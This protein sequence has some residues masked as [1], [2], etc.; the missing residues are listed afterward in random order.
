MTTMERSEL[1]HAG[2]DLDGPQVR[3]IISSLPNSPRLHRV[4]HA[5]KAMMMAEGFLHLSTA[6]IAAR[7]RCSKSTLY[8]LA[9]NADGLFELVVRLWIAEGEDELAV[10]LPARA[11]FAER[12]TEFLSVVVQETGR[13]SPRFLQDAAFITSSHRLIGQLRVRREETLR[14]IIESGVAAWEF[15][16]VNARLVA[17]ML[18]MTVEGVCNPDVLAEVGLPASDA[19]W[20]AWKVLQ[21]GLLL[22]PEGR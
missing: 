4:L 7:Q 5:V 22:D 14:G 10:R 20:D 21:T 16:P 3:A 19:I 9:S 15:R 8:R 17:K 11:S 12:L 6:E 2:P 13:V 18:I 1:M